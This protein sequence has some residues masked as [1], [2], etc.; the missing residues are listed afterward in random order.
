MKKRKLSLSVFPSAIVICAVELIY[1]S[2]FARQFLSIGNIANVMTQSVIP[3]MLVVGVAIV[4]ISGGMDLSVGSVLALSG[5]IAGLVL[6][7]GLP[8][9][10]AAFLGIFTGICCGTING[11]M[12]S[13]VGLPPFIATLAMMNIASGLSNT[14][15]EK[16]PV[17][18]GDNKVLYEIGNGKVF[19][20]PIFA[21]TGVL[22]IGLMITIFYVSRLKTYTFVLGGNEEVL[23]L[24]GVSITKWK[25]LVYALSGFLAGVAGIMMIARV[26][27]ADPTS[28]SGLEFAAVVSAVIGGN[29]QNT[30]RGTLFG[31][32]LGALTIA[33]LRNGLSLLKTQTH[34]QMVI[35]GIVLVLGILIHE[36]AVKQD[37]KL[38]KGLRYGK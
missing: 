37:K 31:A 32:L 26:N 36:F 16:K 38:E 1:F 19:G 12:I 30:G 4:V 3:C 25:I 33:I 13:K 21:L 14:L 23:H 17:Y 20:V 9:Y 28:G 7:A 34:W 8:L 11:I 24:S 27:C 22:I 6:K 10:V 29:V 35:T 18:W 2:L 15:S 5:C